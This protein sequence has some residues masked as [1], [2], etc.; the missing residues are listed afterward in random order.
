[1]RNIWAIVVGVV[2]AGGIGVTVY[3]FLGDDAPRES[4]TMTAPAP[5]ADT[6][7]AQLEIAPPRPEADFG[8]VA[9]GADD[10]ILGKAD[11]PVTIVEYSSLTCPHC[12][13]F[14]STTL[15]GLKKEFIDTGKA[16]L[17]YRDFPLDN[18]ALA[19]SM[20]ARCAG[21]ERYFGFID[22]FFARQNN[23]TQ[24]S[25]P[26]AALGKLARLGGMSQADF[27]VCMKN[28]AV[29][30]LI[31]QQQQKAIENFQL[32]STPTLII[33][34]KK[35]SGALTLEQLRAVLASMLKKS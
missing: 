26:V 34:G 5:A 30:D 8:T 16:R 33:N 28:Q 25:N 31:K 32:K 18:V 29:F 6:A 20:I 2:V 22:V 14:H 3:N 7:M 9:I 35:Y 21:R 27:D 23:W 24:A 4:A 10:F 11:A 1:M 15:P 12:A 19:G 13:R 17:V